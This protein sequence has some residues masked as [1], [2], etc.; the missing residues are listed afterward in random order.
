[1]L[2]KAAND[3]IGP[4]DAAAL[5]QLNANY[6]NFKVLDKLMARKDGA[7]G[8]IS[9]A[10]LWGAVNQRGPKATLAMRELAKVGQGLLKDP[11][12]DSGTA[13]R[14]LMAGAGAGGVATGGIGLAT[15]GK[16][17]LLGATAGRALNSKTLGNYA[18]NGLK[19]PRGKLARLLAEHAD[20]SAAR[21]P[22]GAAAAYD[23]QPLEL[24]IVGG[25][26]VPAAALDA[27]LRAAGY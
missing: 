25:Q 20:R 14:L 9:P 6:R 3:S 8:D 22:Q 16:L 27:Q 7:T 12:P 17:A 21:L 18:A 19:T 11:I 15:L 4:Q 1:V 23:T 24:S 10:M 26:P 2:D 5:A 13:P